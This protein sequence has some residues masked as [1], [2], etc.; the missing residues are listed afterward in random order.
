VVLNGKH[1][2]SLKG[3]LPG[4]LVAWRYNNGWEQIPVQVDE[5][6]YVDLMDIYNVNKYIGY[7]YEGLGRKHVKILT[8]T[9]PGTFTGGDSDATIDDDDEIVFMAKDA[10]EKANTD[11]WPAGVV[12]DTCEEIEVYDIDHTGKA[13]YVYLFKQDG[14]LDPDAGKKYVK[15]NFNLLSGDYKTTYKIGGGP[16]FED[17]T[18]I[19]NSYACHFSD[20]WINDGLYIFKDNAGGVNILD[21]HKNLFAPGN[22]KRSED[23][24]S[25]GSAEGFLEKGALLSINPVL[26]EQSALIWR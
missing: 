10:G 1:I 8:Y 18:I 20:R 13:A 19:T 14:T 11:L 4:E 3:I 21:R 26:L 5:K 12:A 7:L 2:G 23:T 9:D 24:F 25:N 6:D 15:Y 17:S 16:N 22:P